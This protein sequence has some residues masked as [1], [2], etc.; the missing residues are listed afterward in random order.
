MPVILAPGDYRLWLDPAITDPA[1]LQ[2]M[3]AACGNDELL[4]KPVSTHVN[5]VANEDPRCI[6]AERTLF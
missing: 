2:H 5:K 6:E 1:Q 4:A 3:L